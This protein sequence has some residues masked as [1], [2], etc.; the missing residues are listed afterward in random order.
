MYTVISRNECIFCDKV[1][2]LLNVDRIGYVEYNIPSPSS[3]WLLH[4]LKQANIKTVPQIFDSN[5]K[6]IGGYTELK[7]YLK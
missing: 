5:G 2:E 4:L 3:K 6:H 1:K 7:E